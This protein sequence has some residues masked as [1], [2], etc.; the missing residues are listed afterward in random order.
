MTKLRP[1]W[2]KGIYENGK[3]EPVNT[4]FSRAWTQP[5]LNIEAFSIMID[6]DNSNTNNYGAQSEVTSAR[7]DGAPYR[8]GG[9]PYEN[10]VTTANHK[11]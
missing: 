8:G 5:H 4:R 9:V 10:T 11:S 3:G 2:K 6:R 1:V 7:L